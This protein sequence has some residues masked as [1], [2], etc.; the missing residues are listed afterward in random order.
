M[1][2]LSFQLQYNRKEFIYVAVLVLYYIN[3]LHRVDSDTHTHTWPGPGLPFPEVSIDV[4]DG[5]SPRAWMFSTELTCEADKSAAVCAAERTVN[6]KVNSRGGL[7]QTV[8]NPAFGPFPVMCA[9][10]IIHPDGSITPRNHQ[11]LVKI[12]LDLCPSGSEL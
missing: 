10:F 5:L 9:L 12:K 6:L 11:Q 1:P 7:D 8:R 2:Q 4:Q 3:L